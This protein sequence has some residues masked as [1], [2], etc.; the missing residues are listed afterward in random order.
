MF[1]QLR[2]SG[3]FAALLVACAA[4]CTDTPARTPAS[5][6][7]ELPRGPAP[8]DETVAPGKVL[9]TPADQSLT[10]AE[11]LSAGVPAVDRTWSGDDM[12]RASKALSALAQQGKLPRYGS[13]RSGLVFARMTAAENLDMVRDTTASSNVDPTLAYFTA[14][15]DL[16]QVYLAGFQKDQIGD[17]ELVELMGF[18]FRTAVLLLDMVARS[19]R[20]LK[21]T[22]GN[23]QQA[24]NGVARMKN[25]LAMVAAGSITTLGERTSFRTSERLRLL[26]YMKETFPAMLAP[27][28]PDARAEVLTRLEGMAADTALAPLRPGIMDLAAAIRARG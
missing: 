27:L 2:H 17:T 21:P 16:L 28:S 22:D 25:G 4:A 18:E 26:G 10:Q 20:S 11:Y 12:Q 5:H 1:A 15:N 14:T 9:V 8:A 13:A 6:P 19:Q 24:M 7:L 23:Y 3:L